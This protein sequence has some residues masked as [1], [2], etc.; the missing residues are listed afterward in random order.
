MEV[1][2]NKVK[3]VLS[4]ASAAAL[5]AAVLAFPVPARAADSLNLYTF[6]K[7]PFQQE[8]IIKF[9]DGKLEAFGSISIPAGKR[10]VIE[11]VSARLTLPAGQ[12]VFESRITTLQKAGG[13]EGYH[14]LSTNAEGNH[15]GSDFFSISHSLRL[16]SVGYAKFSFFRSDKAQ[17]GLVNAAVSGYLV[18]Y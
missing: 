2:M 15:L 3:R 8:V 1:L 11:H 7:E 5:L 13:A 4:V 10:L 16:Y 12:K 18:D 9:L 17:I 6:P 14:Y